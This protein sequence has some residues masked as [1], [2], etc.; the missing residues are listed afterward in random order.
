MDTALL[1]KAFAALFAI[2]NPFVALPMFLSLTDGQPPADQRR[3][4]L[5]T[6]MYSAL[7]AAI[8][9]VSG[10]AV[11]DFFGI[12]VDDFRIAGGI[13]LLLIGLGMLNGV[14]SSAHTGTKDEQ[15]H[16]AAQDDVSF[17]PMAFPMIVGPGTITTLVLLPGHGGL[18]GHLTTGLAL[19]AVLAMMGAVL[20]FAPSIGH[21]LSQKLRVIMTRLMGM[22]LAAIAVQMVVAGL[23]SVFPALA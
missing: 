11:L 1:I 12:G 20:Y 2:M 14:G 4:G 21:L 13:V 17:Y 7:L 19:L 8:V 18:R 3:A 5:R 16:Q 10:N 22:I 6:T 23:K 15:E 9:L